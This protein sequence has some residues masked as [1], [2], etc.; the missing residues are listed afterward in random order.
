MFQ[1]EYDADA[2][3]FLFC[4]EEAGENLI[5]KVKTFIANKRAFFFSATE[6]GKKNNWI[7]LYK[8]LVLFFENKKEDVQ[9]VT[10]ETVLEY[11]EKQAVSEKIVWIFYHS[12]FLFEADDFTEL[13]KLIKALKNTNNLM[14]CISSS[15]SYESKIAE[16]K[17]EKYI[18]HSS[19]SVGFYSIWNEKTLPSEDK[20]KYYAIFGT[21]DKYIDGLDFSKDLKQNLIENFFSAEGKLLEEPKRI[22]KNELREVQVYNLILEAIAKGYTTLNEI[23][24]KVALPTGVCNKYTTVLLSLNI[25]RKIKPTFGKDTRKSRYAITNPVIDFWYCFVPENMTEIVLD[26]GEWVYDTKVYGELYRYLQLKF[27]GF[28]RE[29][30]Q[31]Q[32]EEGTIKTEIKENNVWWDKDYLID[33]VAGNGLEAIVGDCFWKNEPVGRE[34]FEKLVKKAEHVDLIDRYYYLFSRTGF[35]EEL[36]RIALE[37]ED[38][39]LVSFADMVTT[40]GQEEKPK[41]RGFFFSRK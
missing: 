35:T 36:K 32:K 1:K 4:K 21:R 26:K 17:L 20:F 15:A 33:I 41:K 10:I 24:E 14:I 19:K 9:E 2:F 29:Y 39:T 16:S 23:A 37:R 11:I 18:W 31:K 5:A 22:L 6:F 13:E 25:L 8:E 28:C 38:L 12:E 7:R 30:I 27:P 34:E 40:R 3:S